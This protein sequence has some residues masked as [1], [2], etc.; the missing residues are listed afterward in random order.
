MDLGYLATIFPS[1]FD[2]LIFTLIF[3]MIV[4]VIS[5]ATSIGLSMLDGLGNDSISKIIS[6]YTGLIRGTPLL[7]QM[8]FV[9]FGLPILFGLRIDN[10][11][12]AYLAFIISWVAYLTET[13]RGAISSVEKGQK[14]AAQV[15][16]LSKFQTMFYVVLPQAVSSAMP[17]ITN[18][19][20]SLV[21]GTSILSV[22]GLDDILKA[23]RIAVIRDLR[24]EGFLIAGAFYIL[25]NSLV[26]FVFK[27]LEKY[28]SR[29]KFNEYS[30]NLK[31]K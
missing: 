13:L 20:V 5:M 26:I 22:L 4:F 17:S 9:Y 2:G 19:A 25:F 24:L 11:Q 18:Q 30:P 16:G 6:A 12:S 29:Y 27:K 14:D 15:L 8:Y 21:Y 1:I 28:F 23:A 31:I 7:F 3:W 10:L